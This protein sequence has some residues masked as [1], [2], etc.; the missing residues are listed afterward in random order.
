M[1][2]L[3]KL[4]L[5]WRDRQLP[6]NWNC[7]FVLP[8]WLRAWSESF[9]QES[10]QAIYTVRWR[11]ELAGIA[12]LIIKGAS[13][14]LIGDSEVCDYGDF[15]T[16]PGREA[17]F[18]HLLLTR[19]QHEGITRLDMGR[20]REGSCLLTHFRSSGKIGEWSIN[21]EQAEE[22]YIIRLP[23]TWERFLSELSVKERHE[24]RRKER[25]L[26]DA[27]EIAFRAVEDRKNIESSLD[28]YI[29]LF[30]RNRPDKSRF[31]NDK[32]ERFFRQVS[33][34]MAGEG[35]TRLFFLE[36]DKQ[37]VASVLCFEYRSTVYLYNNGYDSRFMSLSVGLLSKVFSIRDSVARRKQTYNLLKGKESYKR[38]LGGLPS[39]LVR[40]QVIL[41]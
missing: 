31:M 11:G 15:V 21:C 25:R 36:I 22:V 39:Q 2:P 13:A 40:C 26:F 10:R 7:L 35:L 8:P 1:E 41:I 38:R 5:Y 29:D 23:D 3:E 34:E 24:L 6:L 27:G 32:R 4:F 18:I 28:I 30:R 12:P 17:H 14:R 9:G 16:V 20:L 33:G 37:P 19:L